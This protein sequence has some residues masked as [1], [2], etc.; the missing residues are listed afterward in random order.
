MK[1][2][3]TI[4]D[5]LGNSVESIF[6]GEEFKKEE[7]TNFILKKIKEYPFSHTFELWKSTDKYAF[8]FLEL[9]K[10][11]KEN[12]ILKESKYEN[13]WRKLHQ[14]TNMFNLI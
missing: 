14:L 8:V 7:T 5:E 10:K 11:N 9:L 13:K 4:Y 1:F 6:L 3:L 2:Y 12:E